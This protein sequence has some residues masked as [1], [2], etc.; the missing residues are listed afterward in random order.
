M[1][2]AL[3]PSLLEKIP[4]AALCSARSIR[5]AP[6]ICLMGSM[7]LFTTSA[8]RYSSF[9]VLKY[10]EINGLEVNRTSPILVPSGAAETPRP[11]TIL[12]KKSRTATQSSAPRAKVWSKIIPTSKGLKPPMNESVIVSA[13]Y[14]VSVP[15]DTIGFSLSHSSYMLVYNLNRN[16]SF[17]GFV[18][19]IIHIVTPKARDAM[20]FITEF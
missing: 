17:S 12:F 6:C 2:F 18:I 11:F 10:R 1:A 8:V 9:I 13:I 5:L 19:M 15:E 20:R 3:E 7:N 16:T 14:I 4:E